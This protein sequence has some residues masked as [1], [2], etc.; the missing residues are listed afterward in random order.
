ME[1]E[2]MR[3]LLMQ[4]LSDPRW[5]AKQDERYD[6]IVGTEIRVDPPPRRVRES[7]IMAG[8]P[9]PREEEP[10]S[11]EALWMGNWQRSA[12]ALTITRFPDNTVVLDRPDGAR[13]LFR[14]CSAPRNRYSWLSERTSR[15]GR[16]VETDRCPDRFATSSET[17]LEMHR[18]ALAL[19]AEL[20]S[21]LDG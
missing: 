9:P 14:I 2:A 10:G 18:S 21:E 4:K 19:F 3:K 13:T 5:R 12:G 8:A 15:D 11:V 17:L 16:V 6:E 7:V 1:D 20:A